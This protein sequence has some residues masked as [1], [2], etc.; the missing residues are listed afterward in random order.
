M[1]EKKKGFTGSKST[2]TFEATVVETVLQRWT[3]SPEKDDV[4]RLSLVLKQLQAPQVRA[5]FAFDLS[6]LSKILRFA[7]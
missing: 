7:F 1:E 6:T 5:G 3:C 2:Q 4:D